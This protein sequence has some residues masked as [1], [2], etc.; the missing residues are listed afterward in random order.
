MARKR[1]GRGLFVTYTFYSKDSCDRRDTES[2]MEHYV[3]VFLRYV[4]RMTTLHWLVVVVCAIA[5]G[6]FC[7]R[8]SVRAPGIDTLPI[9]S[10]SHQLDRQ[11]RNQ[12]L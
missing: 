1:L 3:Q 2:Q 10:I 12:P 5:F 11:S 8:D 9:P 4:D 7:M 6:A